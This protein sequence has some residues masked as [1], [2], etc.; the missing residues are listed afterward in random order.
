[1][2]LQFVFTNR[3][4]TQNGACGE[5]LNIDYNTP[6]PSEEWIPDIV[7]YVKRLL[8]S[9][10]GH[11]DAPR[12]WIAGTQLPRKLEGA[13]T[14]EEETALSRFRVGVISWHYGCLV[15]EINPQVTPQRHRCDPQLPFRLS[16]TP[17]AKLPTASKP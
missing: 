11:A 10:E 16:N 6:T 9:E 15:P 4:V 2:G 3:V 14:Q 5:L 7:V 12:C 13:V 8:F 1:M 17:A